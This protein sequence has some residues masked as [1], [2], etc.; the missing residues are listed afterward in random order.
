MTQDN[1]DDLPSQALIA[2]LITLRTC[3][4]R[5]VLAWV[6]VL[7]PLLF[8]SNEIFEIVARPLLA[9]LPVEKKSSM[10]VTELTAAFMIPFKLTLFVAAF[11]TL[12]FFLYQIWSFIAPILYKR[13]KKLAR[14]L[15]VSSVVLFY[16]GVAFAY[17][18]VFP[19]IFQFFTQVAP[20]SIRVM[21]DISSHLDFVMKLFL[22]FGAAFEI[23]VATVVLIVMGIVSPKALED[24][25]G[26]VV[27]SCFVIAMVLTPPDVFSQTMLAVPMW[28]LFEIGVYAGK[29]LIRDQ[30]NLQDH[31]TI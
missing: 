30:D 14:L 25:R 29:V 10:I 5:S 12:P 24:K 1:Q 11:L 8:Y 26:I 7:I 17:F 13:G 21:P 28:L 18:V 20:E 22:A 15:F 31:E 19:L 16:M 2:H 6:V 9:Y 27:V 4:I 23:P 3:L